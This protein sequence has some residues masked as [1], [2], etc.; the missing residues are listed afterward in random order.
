MLV[1]GNVQPSHHPFLA[2]TSSKVFKGKAG[3]GKTFFFVLL[4]SNN[5]CREFLECSSVSS[6]EEP[7]CY[8]YASDDVIAELPNSILA[9]PSLLWDVYMK[10]CGDKC[11]LCGICCVYLLY[12]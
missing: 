4:Q 11:I 1:Q 5:L 2:E 7:E 9:S 10:V 12:W 6:H 3:T 8:G